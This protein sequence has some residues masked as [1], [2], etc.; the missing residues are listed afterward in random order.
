MS[1]HQLIDVDQMEASKL[2]RKLDEPWSPE[3]SKRVKTVI[4]DIAKTCEGGITPTEPRW[5]HSVYPL[6]YLYRHDTR[7]TLATVRN[8]ILDDYSSLFPEFKDKYPTDQLTRFVDDIAYTEVDLLIEDVNY[9]IFVEAK[10]PSN[11]KL[12]KFEMKH[13]VHQLVWIYAEGLFLARKIKKQFHL[14]TLGTKMTFHNLTPADQTLLDLLGD[15][16]KQLKFCDL[17]W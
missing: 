3:K 15:T 16:S 4:A 6:Y 1:N 8:R 7:D 12:P 13:G 9:F 10:N 5:E 14:A 17:S 11:G 2:R